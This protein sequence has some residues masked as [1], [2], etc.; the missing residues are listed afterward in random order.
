MYFDNLL[1]KKELC[2][3]IFL[4]LLSIS[5]ELVWQVEAPFNSRT[6]WLVSFQVNLQQ[7]LR[8]KRKKDR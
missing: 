3:D 2:T 8:N 7:P 5:P 6:S 1:R 4:Q